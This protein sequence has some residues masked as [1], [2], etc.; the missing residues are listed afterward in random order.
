MLVRRSAVAMIAALVSAL[1]LMRTG[2][3]DDPPPPL[4]PWLAAAL[5]TVVIPAHQDLAAAAGDTAEAVTVLCAAPGRITLAGAQAHYVTLVRAWSR[6][7]LYRF[8]P[9]RRDNL[10]E[11]LFFWPD[12]RGRGLRQVQRLIATEDITAADVAALKDKSVAVQGLPALEYLLFGLGSEQL[13]EPPL[14]QRCRYAEAVAQAVADHAALLLAGWTAAGGQAEV[15]TGAG[16]GNALYRDSDEAMAELLR[17]AATQLEIL[18]DL[19]LIA[20]LGETPGE[21]KPGRAPFARSGLALAAMGGNVDAVLVLFAN[22]DMPPPLPREFGGYAE[23]LRFELEQARRVLGELDIDAHGWAALPRNEV[24]QDKLRYIVHP[25]GGALRILRQ[26]YAE[27]LG[28]NL[29]F[30]AMDGD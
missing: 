20:M 12:R 23:S 2:A 6:V 4:G 8:G 21:T 27:A 15:M 10:H 14:G 19:K 18:R 16:P 24:A 25:L 26:D 29:G 5:Q 30:N 1:L 28:I 7:E 3:A 11:R 22:P 9:A 13:A 17:A